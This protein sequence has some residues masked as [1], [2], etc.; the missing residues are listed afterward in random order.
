MESRCRFVVRDAMML[1]STQDPKWQAALETPTS[2]STSALE[3][4]IPNTS[5]ASIAS[6]YSANSVSSITRYSTIPGN[7]AF[8]QISPVVPKY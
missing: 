6:E 7:F 1:E 5:S 2:I 8:L 3:I 4:Y